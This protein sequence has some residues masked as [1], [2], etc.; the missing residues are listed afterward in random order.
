MARVAYGSFI[1]KLSGSIGGSTFQRNSSNDICR[2][3]PLKT[4]NSTSK[5]QIRQHSFCNSVVSWNTIDPAS[6][7]AWQS[8]AGLHP[9]LNYWGD[10]KQLN[11]YQFFISCYNYANILSLTPL[12]LP[13]VYA[14]VAIPLAPSCIISAS[15]FVVYLESL[16]PVGERALIY[17]SMPLRNTGLNQRKNLYL[18]AVIHNHSTDEFDLTTE[19]LSCF[20]L[21]S[22]PS[23]DFC[24]FGILLGQVNVNDTT[25]LCSAMAR[26]YSITYPS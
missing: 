8:F 22:L 5:Q 20:N 7:A 10:T 26:N 1:T 17:V 3:K 9:K 19:Y 23:I 11:G 2:S 14:S 13:P 24:P 18:L 6:K 21:L 16:I 4:R 15:T 25:F 12:T